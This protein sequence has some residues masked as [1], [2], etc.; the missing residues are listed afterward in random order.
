MVEQK[1]TYSCE[2]AFH[3][4][5]YYSHYKE[6]LNTKVYLK[7]TAYKEDRYNYKQ[8]NYNIHTYVSE[9]VYNADL[10]TY[11]L[12]L[13]IVTD[14]RTN[15]EFLQVSIYDDV[16]LNLDERWSKRL[17]N[18][19]KDLLY[20]YVFHVERESR[21]ILK[22]LRDSKSSSKALSF[23]LYTLTQDTTFTRLIKSGIISVICED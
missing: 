19:N 18:K 15:K 13:N 17:L 16:Y 1:I 5:Y 9:T 11:M 21:K 10:Y 6:I 8:E 14:T 4:D 20:F 12:Y 7:N 22:Y 3:E 2:S 23:K